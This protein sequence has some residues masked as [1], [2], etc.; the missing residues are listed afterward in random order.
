M[1]KII[2]MFCVFFL[3]VLAFAQG[4]KDSAMVER[5]KLDIDLEV[6]QDLLF[7]QTKVRFLK[8]ISDSRCPRQVTCIWAGEAKVLLGIELKGEYFERE[9]VISGSGAELPLAEDFLMQVS[10]LRPYPETAKGIDPRQYCLR[11][12]AMLSKEDI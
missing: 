10:H 3:P 7:G 9:V 12:A 4:E 11:F 6:G 1:K 5:V 2:F 8:V